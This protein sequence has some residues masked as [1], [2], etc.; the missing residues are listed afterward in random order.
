MRMQ[1]VPITNLLFHVARLLLPQAA[2]LALFGRRVCVPMGQA[3][4]AEMRRR[5]M[6]RR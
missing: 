1:P 2:L 5:V 6:S 3:S 4:A